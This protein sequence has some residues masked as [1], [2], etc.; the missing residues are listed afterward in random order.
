MSLTKEVRALPV[1]IMLLFFL[2]VSLQTTAAASNPACISQCWTE[3]GA[4][5]FAALD[6]YSSF[7]I[8]YVNDFNVT[9]AGIVFMVIHDSLGQTVEISTSFLQLEPDANG[10]AY[11]IAWG[12]A[13]GLYAATFFVVSSSGYAI[14]VTSTAAFAV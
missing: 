8:L 9:M 4:P 10:T 1:V 3:T 7:E 13:S 12:L 14:S 11:P 2:V 6:S 5:V